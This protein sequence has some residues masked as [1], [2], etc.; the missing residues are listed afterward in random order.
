MSADLIGRTIEDEDGWRVVSAVDDEAGTA[1]TTDKHGTEREED[2][3]RVRRIASPPETATTA[4]LRAA[5][6]TADEM[7]DNPRYGYPGALGY[8]RQFVRNMIERLENGE[9]A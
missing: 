1:W 7:I 5:V 4:A 2:L 6:R 3:N 9:I 8:L